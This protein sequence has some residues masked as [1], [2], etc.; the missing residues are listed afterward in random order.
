MGHAAMDRTSISPSAAFTVRTS[1]ESEVG[2]AEGADGFVSDTRDLAEISTQ[3]EYAVCSPDDLENLPKATKERLISDAHCLTGKWIAVFQK[4]RWIFAGIEAVMA[5]GYVTA[6]V[7][8]NPLLN[9]CVAGIGIGCGFLAAVFS[10]LADKLKDKNQ[11]LM[12]VVLE[13]GMAIDI[14][15]ELAVLIANAVAQNRMV[16]A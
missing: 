5:C 11:F 15:E 3:A 12:Q 7:R 1:Q 4:G 6:L 2:V 16:E 8:S 10:K 9:N 13:S 14:P